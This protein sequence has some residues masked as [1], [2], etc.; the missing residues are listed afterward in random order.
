MLHCKPYVAAARTSDV[1]SFSGLENITTFSKISKYRQYQKYHIFYIFDIFDSFDIYQ[2][3]K[4]S[5]KLYSN[6]CNTLIQYLMTSSVASHLYNT[7]KFSFCRTILCYVRLMTWAIRLC[8]WRRYALPRGLNFRQ[9][10]ST[11]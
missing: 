4:I 9:Y 1:S 3:M 5:N 8:L 2:K 11:T 7:L 10:F 6:G